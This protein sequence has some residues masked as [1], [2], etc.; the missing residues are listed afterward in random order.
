MKLL[1][2]TL[3]L[4]LTLL[5]VLVAMSGPGWDQTQTGVLLFI[6]GQLEFIQGN[7]HE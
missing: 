4:C 7:Q 6:A 1:C 5:G 3:G 2:F